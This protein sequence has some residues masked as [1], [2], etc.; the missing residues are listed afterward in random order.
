MKRCLGLALTLFALVIAPGGAASAD[1]VADFYHGKTV[2][3]IIGYGVG[4]G[5]DLYARI[6]TEFLGKHIPG[7]PR[8]LPENMTGAGSFVAAKYL[9]EVAPHDG[10]VLGSLA[11]TF[12]LDAAVGT[13]GGIDVTQFH[14]IGRLTSSIDLGVALP[15]AG[16]KSFDD[17]RKQEFTVGSSGGASTAVLLPASLNAFGGAKFKIVRGYKGAAEVLLALERGEVQI[18]GAVGIPLLLARHPDWITPGKATIVYQAAL[19]RSQYLPQVPTLPEL[20]LTEDGRA[21]LRAIAGTAEIGRSIITTPGVPND[22][23]AALRKAFQDMIVDPDFVE[24]C[25]QRHIMLDPDTG[26]DIDAILTETVNLP[27]PVIAN[28][29]ILVRQ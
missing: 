12:A 16:I 25:K 4:G 7:N 2:R 27:K 24:A 10:T 15:D 13:S 26:E 1:P 3:M 17:V 21:V 19:K 23:L 11:Q 6:A 5:Y 18:A 20:G 9:S 8:L 14:Y 29:G 22:R 28:L